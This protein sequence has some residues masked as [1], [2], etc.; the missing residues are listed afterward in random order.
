MAILA[1]EIRVLDTLV[2]GCH[3]CSPSIFWEIF[4]KYFA[5][6]TLEKKEE[7]LPSP[8]HIKF[9]PWVL[10]HVFFFSGASLFK[11][12]NNSFVIS[13]ISAL[14]FRDWTC[15]MCISCNS[16]IWCWIPS[17][18]VDHTVFLPEQVQYVPFHSFFNMFAFS[19]SIC[20][21]YRIVP[22]SCHFIFWLIHSARTILIFWIWLEKNI[23]VIKT[24]KY[25]KLISVPFYD[26]TF[27]LSL[28]RENCTEKSSM[29]PHDHEI[30][31]HKHDIC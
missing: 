31:Y 4:I 17:R 3:F 7:I 14:S 13:I 25:L 26:K 28:M 11:I 18:E 2:A 1:V 20:I 30:F 23:G 10:L 19:G 24:R 6:C 15:H 9:G 22:R 16:C 29:H 21:S 5:V 27:F 8:K 12:Q